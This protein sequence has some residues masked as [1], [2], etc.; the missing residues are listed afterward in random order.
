MF[1]AIELDQ[2]ISKK[3]FQDLEPELRTNLLNTQYEILESDIS[4]LIIIS[5]VEGAGKS[6]VVNRLNEWLDARWVRNHAFWRETEE[7]AMHPRYWRF[8]KALPGKGRFAVMF[9]SWYTKPIIDRV[10]KKISQAKLNQEMEHIEELERMLSDDNMLII[11]FWFHLSKKTSIERAKDSQALKSP[12]QKKFA[13][14]YDKFVETCEVALR[15]T[16]SGHAPWHLIEATDDRYRDISVGQILLDSM[17]NKLKEMENCNKK[18]TRK[19]VIKDHSDTVSHKTVLDTVNLDQK[20]NNEKYKKQLKLYQKKLWQLSWKAYNSQRSLVAV[21]EGWDAAGKGG[22]IRR[23]TAAMDARLYN[24]ISIAA[25]TDEE[26]A[27]HYFWRF[28]RYLP[29]DGYITIYDRSWY[30]R[31][32]VE[33]VE[34]FAKEEEWLRSYQEINNFEEEM[35]EHGLILLKF[36]IHISKDEQLRRFKERE[37]TPWKQHKITDEDWRNRDKWDN[38][39]LAVNEMVARTSTSRAPWILVPGNDKKIAR[40]T[41]IKNVCDALQAAL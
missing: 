19:P 11:K 15:K 3:E 8:W 21:F 2:K 26:K 18:R 20:I 32:L 30:G 23:T 37:V 14:K 33:R 22:A 17:R 4:V 13:K 12:L 25:P 9:G 41:V 10:M 38:Y 31:V 27:Q 40:I 7:M 36:W 29:L 39:E 6:E 5:G 1:E 24:I 28:W 16:D 35:T 34:G